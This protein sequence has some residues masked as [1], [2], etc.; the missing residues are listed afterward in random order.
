MAVLLLLERPLQFVRCY[1]RSFTSSSTRPWA[2]TRART[3]KRLWLSNPGSSRRKSLKVPFKTFKLMKGF[4]FPFYRPQQQQQQQARHLDLKYSET[5]R[6]LREENE[7]NSRKQQQQPHQ[8]Q[9]PVD[10]RGLKSVHHS[11]SAP[12]KTVAS[13]PHFKVSSYP[14]DALY[15]A[16]SVFILMVYKG[17]VL[18]VTGSYIVT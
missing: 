3:S 18:C 17:Q 2:S 8:Q 10:A 1:P 12:M 15:S 16:T 13:N 11:P 9:Q 7:N 6:V 4:V 5:L 14:G